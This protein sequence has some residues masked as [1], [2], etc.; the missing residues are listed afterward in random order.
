MET[1]NDRIKDLET[2]VTVLTSA[3]NDILSNTSAKF[4]TPLS[5]SGGNT[6]RS[7]HRP[8]DVKS[9]FGQVLGGAVIWND[10]EAATPPL[11]AEPP[12]PKLGYNKHSHSRYSGG[13]LIKDVLEIVEYV[14]GSIVNKQSQAYWVE[15]PTI[16]KYLNTKGESVDAVG[17][18]DL[19]FEPDTIKW[20][21]AAYEIDI[22]KCKFVE[23]DDD[24]NIIHSAP[25]WNEDQTKSSIVWDE[26]GEC[27]R[28]FSAYSTGA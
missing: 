6:D 21:V 4:T 22:K 2:Q 9:G 10:S 19:I 27:W 28:L 23:R 26:L 1:L 24:G 14:W 15:Q 5:I 16:K 25:L 11:N 12:L 13:A 3:L 7:T 20:G 17:L 18:L 8:I